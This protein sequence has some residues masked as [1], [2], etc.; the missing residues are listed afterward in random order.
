MNLEQSTCSLS[1]FVHREARI[2]FDVIKEPKEEKEVVMIKNAQ[3]AQ[4]R[5]PNTKLRTESKKQQ[6]HQGC[7]VVDRRRVVPRLALLRL[8]ML[9]ARGTLSERERE[10]E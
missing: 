3:Y 1:L 2:F 10:G 5:G 4:T 7:L 8:C 9:N 6:T